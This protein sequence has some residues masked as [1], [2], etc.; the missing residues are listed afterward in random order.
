MSGLWV[1][2]YIRLKSPEDN[3][4]INIRLVQPSI[5]QRQKWI[6]SF[7]EKNLERLEFL[8]TSSVEKNIH[9]TIWPEAAVTVPLDQY[10]DL[11]EHLGGML[12]KGYL[13]TGAPRIDHEK[14]QVFSSLHVI[15]QSGFIHA[16][17]DKFHLVPFGEYV[18]LRKFNP[19]P[20]LT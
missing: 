12:R 4:P 18:P 13:I 14:S 10:I 9:I 11:A 15:D 2:G 16:T 17:F 8:T 3:T 5:D 20:K 7:F 19:F 6:P 1:D